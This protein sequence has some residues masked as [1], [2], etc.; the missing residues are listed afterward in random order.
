MTIQYSFNIRQL[1]FKTIYGLSN[2][3]SH[4]HFDYIGIHQNGNKTFCQGTLPFDLKPTTV[5]NP[6]TG[7]SIVVPAIFDKNNYIP[8][9]QITDEIIVDWLNNLVP[10]ETI[11]IF[12]QIISEKLNLQE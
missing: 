12:Q 8:Y 2:I 4:V 3:I 7:E 1:T 11:Q 10:S 5:K 6:V 9:D